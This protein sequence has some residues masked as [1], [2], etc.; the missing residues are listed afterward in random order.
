MTIEERLKS[1]LGG[2][3]FEL[4]AAYAKIEALE[5]EL[6]SKLEPKAAVV[7]DTTEPT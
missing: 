3:I 4:H 5:A 2:L 6:K 1:Y 7:V